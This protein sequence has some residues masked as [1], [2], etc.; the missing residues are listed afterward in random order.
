MTPGRRRRKAALAGLLA[1]A[2]TASACGGDDDDETGTG[3]DDAADAIDTSAEDVRAVPEEYDTIQAAVDAADEGD[4]VLVSPGTYKEAVTVTTADITIRGLD[5]NEVI[6]DGDFE[7]D[8]GDGF[9]D[10]DPTEARLDVRRGA[11]SVDP[12]VQLLDRSG[13]KSAGR[14]AY[15]RRIR[16]EARPHELA[17]VTPGARS[18]RLAGVPRP[19]DPQSGG[20]AGDERDQEQRRAA[21]HGQ[22]GIK[23]RC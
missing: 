12:V 16:M 20:R 19:G 23:R 18:C 6:L 7:M 21:V 5:R 14:V 22:P 1:L 3:G 9:E 11:V 10:L 8:N 15:E 17:L 4:L 13:Q 2:I